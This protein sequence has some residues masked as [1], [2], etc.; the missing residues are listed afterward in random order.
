MLPKYSPFNTYRL[1]WC[2]YVCVLFDL[3]SGTTVS[4][5]LASATMATTQS[6]AVCYLWDSMTSIEQASFVHSVVGNGEDVTECNTDNDDVIV[7][8]L[9]DK[10]TMNSMKRI[11]LRHR[12]ADADY[13]QYALNLCNINHV[14]GAASI[15]SAKRCIADAL[16]DDEGAKQNML[17][18]WSKA[19]RRH[20]R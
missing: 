12:E 15:K 20:L 1:T 4:V 5:S 17:S 9:V 10:K 11:K 7:Q 19:N 13:P 18:N 6:V 16:N 8:C 14:I 2:V 3:Y